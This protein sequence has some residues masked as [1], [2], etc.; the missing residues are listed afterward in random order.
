MRV[1]C[2]SNASRRWPP[3]RREERRSAHIADRDEVHHA[4]IRRWHVLRSERRHALSATLAGA[5][6]A[7]AQPGVPSSAWASRRSMASSASAAR[8][9]QMRP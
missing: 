9:P 1:L 7:V 2:T 3:A 5:A 8:R 6:A 4:A